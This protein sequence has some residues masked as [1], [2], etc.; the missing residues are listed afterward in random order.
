MSNN[1]VRTNNIPS[2]IAASKQNWVHTILMA[3]HCSTSALKV[4]Q[5]AKLVEK[6]EKS[7]QLTLATLNDCNV[8]VAKNGGYKL[9]KFVTKEDILI[10]S[11]LIQQ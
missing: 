11:N 7:I 5:L 10:H 9:A 3:L 2:S 1:T 6:D 8:I 4:G